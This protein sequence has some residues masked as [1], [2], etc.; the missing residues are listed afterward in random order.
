MN[1]NQR[2]AVIKKHSMVTYM[3]MLSKRLKA[4]LKDLT[5]LTSHFTHGYCDSVED[6]N[7]DDY[8]P[9]T[10]PLLGRTNFDHGYDIFLFCKLIFQPQVKALNS[11]KKW[12][13][14]SRIFF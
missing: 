11:N 10:F 8:V 9:E 12:N 5:R 13:I 7:C 2:G 4:D 14:F 6:D 1:E 3:E